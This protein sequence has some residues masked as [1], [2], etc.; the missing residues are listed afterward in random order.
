MAGEIWPFCCKFLIILVDI[1]LGNNYLKK[2]KLP[3]NFDN[4]INSDNIDIY[5][6]IL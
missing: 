5:S 6:K 2:L 4:I 1:L 3:Y